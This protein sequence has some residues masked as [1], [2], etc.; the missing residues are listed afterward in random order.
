VFTRAQG[1]RA[2]LGVLDTMLARTPNIQKLYQAMQE[3]FDTDPV[4]FVSH[5]A[6]PF[7]PK[8]MNDSAEETVGGGDQDKGSVLIIP[9]NG[10]Q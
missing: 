1:R 8:S 3:Q 9:S 2:I 7:M 6:L 5:V 4:G 10:R